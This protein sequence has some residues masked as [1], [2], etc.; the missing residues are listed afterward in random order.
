VIV[1]ALDSTTPSGSIAVA[2][3]DGSIAARPGDARR[4]W[5]GRLP[6]EIVELLDAHRLRPI[7]VGIFAVAAGPGSLTGLRVGIATVQGFAFATGRRVVPVSALDALAEH[8]CTREGAE[9]RGDVVVAWTNAMRG[10][11]FS[12]LY[13]PRRPTAPCDDPWE[14]VRA[15]TVGSPDE[16][17]AAIAAT[18][19][20]GVVAVGDV[21]EALSGPLSKRFG[22]RLT[23][24]ER[25]LLAPLIAR[26]AVR[27]A[28]RGA[29]VSPHAVRPLYV[30]KPDAVLA[31][32]RRAAPA[33]DDRV[34]G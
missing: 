7:D 29:A 34:R 17:A 4:G 22:E 5:S 26:M 9:P 13:A 19:P 27:L 2:L 30:R 24:L 15:A 21:E 25:P 23:L 28:D 31:R 3:G 1:L 8:A 32:E 20:R 10:E 6:G 33:A 14:R 18:D 12:A 11:V 16:A